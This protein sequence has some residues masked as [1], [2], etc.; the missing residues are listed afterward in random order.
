LNLISNNKVKC[1]SEFNNQNNPINKVS[2]ILHE[3]AGYPIE[4]EKFINK[5]IPKFSCGLKNQID[6]LNG[7]AKCHNSSRQYNYNLSISEL[8][9]SY[10][11]M[12]LNEGLNLDNFEIKSTNNIGMDLG[13]YAHILKQDL[14]G[15]SDELF[16]LINTSVSGNYSLKLE[17]YIQAFEKYPNLGLLGISYSTK[18]YQTL[19]RNNFTPHLQSFFLV[20][21]SSA[22]KKMLSKNNNEFPGEFEKNKLALIRFGEAKITSMIQKIGYEVGVVEPNGI[23]HFIPKSELFDNGYNS[24]VLPHGDRRLT[25]EAPNFVHKLKFEE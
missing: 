5:S 25:N 16:F 12:L 11:Q 19:I 4:R 18:V 6:S 2:F 7:F 13:G 15:K 17:G 8:T 14:T 24:W 1:P 21:R 10:L 23:L 22:L 20:A 9:D 3:W